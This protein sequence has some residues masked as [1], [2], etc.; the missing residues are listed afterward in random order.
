VLLTAI[1]AVFNRHQGRYGHR[2]VHEI[3]RRQGREC[4]VELVQLKS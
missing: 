3:L 2:R 4:S 1:T